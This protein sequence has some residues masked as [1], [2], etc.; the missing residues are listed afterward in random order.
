MRLRGGNGSIG[1]SKCLSRCIYAVESKQHADNDNSLFRYLQTQVTCTCAHSPTRADAPIIRALYYSR[2]Q[3]FT[4]P[5]DLQRAPKCSHPSTGTHIL[6]MA[7]AFNLAVAWRR[8]QYPSPRSI[9]R[10]DAQIDSLITSDILAE[11]LSY[12]PKLILHQI[13]SPSTA[14]CSERD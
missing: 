7:T 14:S 11:P 2:A 10:L 13:P 3:G 4:T 6:R 1:A 12:C 5:H 8:Q 9:S